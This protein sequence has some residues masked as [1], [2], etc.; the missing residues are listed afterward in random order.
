MV[1]L[2]LLKFYLLAYLLS[3]DWL[4]TVLCSMAHQHRYQSFCVGQLGQEVE[5]SRETV[6]T[7]LLDIYQTLVLKRRSWQATISQETRILYL[8]N[9]TWS[10][11]IEN[12]FC[13]PQLCITATMKDYNLGSYSTQT[14]RWTK[15]TA[16]RNK[17]IFHIIKTTTFQSLFIHQITL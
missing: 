12:K 6:P 1:C 2:F 11:K 5:D 15:E 8:P 16:M 7:I 10:T 4:W 9:C 17:Q 14:G 13:S 3:V